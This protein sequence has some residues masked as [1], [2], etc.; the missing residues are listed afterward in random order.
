MSDE[1][2]GDS[3]HA[4][5]G[6]LCVGEPRWLLLAACCCLTQ[7]VGF[8]RLLCFVRP[9]S[10]SN[11]GAGWNCGALELWSRAEAFPPPPL[12]VL[13]SDSAAKLAIPAGCAGCPRL[14]PV[15]A[16][17][18]LPPSQPPYPLVHAVGAQ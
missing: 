12:L 5:E 10:A 1:N 18:N 13:P 4:S 7:S 14:T 9:G 16:L 11:G 17:P 15:S 8:G 6:G 3:C 2:S